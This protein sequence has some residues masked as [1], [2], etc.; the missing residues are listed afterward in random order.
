MEALIDGC[1]V[2]RWHYKMGSCSVSCGGG[3]AHR[4]LY[5]A[6]EIGDKEEEIV[7]AAQC[8]GLPRPEEQELCNL[9]P[10]PPR[11]FW[12]YSAR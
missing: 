5:C 3:V 1:V 7:A 11:S 8:H 10:C 9:E 12:S 2:P 6:R 4:V